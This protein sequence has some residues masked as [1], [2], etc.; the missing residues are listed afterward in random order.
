MR[1]LVLLVLVLF[2]TRP[3]VA[4]PAV[5]NS[6]SSAVS[7]TSA[8]PSRSPAI[9]ANAMLLSVVNFVDSIKRL[10]M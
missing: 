2:A 10:R 8:R 5:T 6:I 4:A 3:C 7:V 1:I 9:D